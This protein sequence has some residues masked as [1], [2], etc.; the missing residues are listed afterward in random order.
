[1]AVLDD[2]R[3]TVDSLKQEVKEL[4]GKVKELVP[5]GKKNRE[6][7]VKAGQI[8]RDEHPVAA[9]QRSTNQ[10]FDQFFNDFGWP[11][12][13]RNDSFG[14]PSGFAGVGRVSLDIKETED[15][16]E[17]TADLPG[18]DKDEIKVTLL[19]SRLTIQGEKKQEEEIKEGDYYRMERSYGSFHRSVW[20]PCEVEPG[21]VDATYKK[22]VL[23]ISLAK[24]EQ[25]KAVSSKIP[26]LAG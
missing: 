13:R 16:L 20:L 14:L 25:A 21:Q 22:G 7:P 2:L 19:G 26:V 8:A 10:L 23:T 6:M 24:S 11:L 18:L 5:F 1:M 9:L 12:S 4:K 17:V 15:A 3:E